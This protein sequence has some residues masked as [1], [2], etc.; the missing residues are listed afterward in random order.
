MLSSQE[1][2]IFNVNAPAPVTAI[3][4]PPSYDFVALAMKGERR[5]CLGTSAGTVEER[6]V[7]DGQL[8]RSF[9]VCSDPESEDLKFLFYQE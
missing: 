9:E 4:S 5:L 7:E 6:K 8:L 3:S 1:L 2:K